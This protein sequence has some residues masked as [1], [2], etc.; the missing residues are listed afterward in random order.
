MVLLLYISS[1]SSSPSVHHISS[2][3]ISPNAISYLI[4][5]PRLTSLVWPAVF[6]WAEDDTS[7]L[8]LNYT[9]SQS[10]SSR[11]PLLPLAITGTHSRAK[12]R[13]KIFP[14]Q[15][16]KEERCEFCG[17]CVLV[18]RLVMQPASACGIQKRKPHLLNLRATI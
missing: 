1:C 6:F 14:D 8:T 7:D 16:E 10:G 17:K 3:S 15:L 2:M 11:D 4:I 9:L 5:I 18:E 12:W 13:R